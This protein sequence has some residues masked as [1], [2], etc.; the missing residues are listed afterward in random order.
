MWRLLIMTNH[1]ACVVVPPVALPSVLCLPDAVTYRPTSTPSALQVREL[2]LSANQLRSQMQQDRLR[3]EAG[4]SLGGSTGLGLR[5]AAS[6]NDT[7]LARLRA[8]AHL[9]DCRGEKG[10]DKNGLL[11]SKR[12]ALMQ[13]AR[14]IATTSSVVSSV[15]CRL[16]STTRLIAIF[17]LCA[18]EDCVSGQLLIT[19]QPMEIR[20]FELLYRP[21]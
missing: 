20:T 5:S 7:E 16:L 1:T 11:V 9:I 3:F 18:A 13:L 21:Y 10:R 15:M 2:S 4:D 17:M 12:S 6:R 14:Q 8:G 19:L